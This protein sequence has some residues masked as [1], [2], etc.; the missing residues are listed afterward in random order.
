MEK[1]INY[2]TSEEDISN[3]V[4]D[5][6]HLCHFIDGQKPL[7]SKSKEVLGKNDLFKIN[8]LLHFCK[9]IAAPNYQ[10]E[11][12]PVIDLMFHLAVLGKLYLRTGDLKGNVYLESTERKTEFDLLN[13]F[14]K[15]SFL[16]ETF[17]T[18]YDF[19]EIIRWGDNPIHEIVHKIA[20]SKAGQKLIKGSFSKR[21]DHD[22]VFS[23][24]SVLIHYFSY[25]GICTFVP[26]VDEN[27]KLTKYDDNL[28]EV[29][30]TEFGVNICGVLA[31][32]KVT[33]WNI[34]FLE[35][36]GIYYD[37]IDENVEI[38]EAEDEPESVPLFK[39]FA[40][41]FPEGVLIKT[42]EKETVKLVKGS[43]IFQVSL[44][45]TVWRKIKISFKH[46]LEDLHLAIQEAFDFDNDHLYA[47]F[48]DGKRY[49]RNAYHS[50]MGDEGPF[51]DEAIIGELGLY[52]GQKIL[53]FFDYGDSWEFG[54]QL[55][56]INEDER[57]PK[58]PEIIEIKGEAP[59]QYPDYEDFDEGE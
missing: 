54:V 11:S 23:Y 6:M 7:L 15:Y 36:Y 39:F 41:V 14:E 17:W 3:T 24:N 18:Q 37:E 16:L 45:R 1:K 27:K 42:V 22:P 49:S 48:M 20:R 55:L 12:Y 53:Y 43:Y 19:T 40:P 58:K 34:P 21:K 38:D 13:S 8:A 33:E 50:P 56:T 26:I 35:E 9:D 59:D 30:P 44:G 10:Q 31:K 5:F 25:F 4:N 46:S 2:K 32:Q 28:K 29:I 57:P 47:F 52:P 51:T